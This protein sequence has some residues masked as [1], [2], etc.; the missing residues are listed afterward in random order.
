MKTLIIYH[1]ASGNTEKVAKALAD[2]LNADLIKALEIQS[3][4]ISKYD[5]IGLGSGVYFGR[6]HASLFSV[7]EKLGEIKN[8]RFFIFSTSGSGNNIFNKPDDLLKKKLSSKGARVL[9]SFGCRGHD[10]FGFFKL[11]GGLNKGHPDEKDLQSAKAFAEKL[12]AKKLTLC[13]I[14]KDG[15]ILLGMKKRGFGEGRWNGFG[16]KVEAG[17]SI[18]E[19][20]RREL[21]EE[22]TIRAGEVEELGIINFDYL[23]TNKFLEVHIFS[24]KEYDGEPEE[25]EEM[26]P[27]WFY[28][29]EIPFDNMWPDDAYWFPLFL[30]GKNFR[31]KFLFEDNNKIIDRELESYE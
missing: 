19:G 31:G 15:R 24:V 11:I 27:Q 3:I 12:K 9:D 23:D 13:L 14:A 26:R 1:S 5:L 22:S 10:T 8:K 21:L 25:T 6:H 7:M 28:L 4:D 16:G 29:D 20:A 30:R 18:V 17:E 2:E